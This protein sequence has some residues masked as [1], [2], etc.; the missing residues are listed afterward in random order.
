MVVALKQAPELKL[1]VGGRTD[2]IG[3]AESNLALSGARAKSVMKYLSDKGI[4]S[5]AL[6]AKGYG[7]TSPVADNRGKDGRAENRP[8]ELTRK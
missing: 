1:E 4:A 2:N 7:Q 8:V 3:A 6:T 5:S